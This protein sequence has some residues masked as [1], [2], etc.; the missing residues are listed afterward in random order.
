[1]IKD[2]ITDE[3]VRPEDLD[4]LSEMHLALVCAEIIRK[5]E[6]RVFALA[7]RHHSLTK[8][9]E[10]AK[11]AG[12]KLT[13]LACQNEQ[14]KIKQQLNGENPQAIKYVSALVDAQG[15]FKDV[16]ALRRAQ[17]LEANHIELNKQSTKGSIT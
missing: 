11:V 7:Y 17:E 12:D 14:R 15:Q 2:P 5:L 6:G 13:V 1:M 8:E 10:A 4:A 3:V 16:T 9:I